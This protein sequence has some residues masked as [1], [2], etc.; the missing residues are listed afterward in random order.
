MKVTNELET[1]LGSTLKK[2]W[3][4]EETLK[5]STVASVSE[6]YEVGGLSTTATP[7]RTG[8]LQSTL[9]AQT[10]TRPDLRFG[11]LGLTHYTS[12]NSTVRT[13]S[14]YAGLAAVAESAAQVLNFGG[15]LVTTLLQANLP[16]KFGQ[17]ASQSSHCE[18]GL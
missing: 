12:R 16:K 18:E 13:V 1:W 4:R 9:G 6:N 5:L 11:V 7:T 17:K 3:R 14:S 10:S 2:F 15:V 8:P